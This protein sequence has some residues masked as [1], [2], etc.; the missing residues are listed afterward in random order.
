MED[1]PTGFWDQRAVGLSDAVMRE[2]YR[3]TR[4]ELAASN[5]DDN[6]H[7]PNATEHAW[8]GKPFFTELDATEKPPN[9]FS[10]SG[11]QR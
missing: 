5:P 10:L 1:S 11:C 8:Q 6:A 2:H 9:G 7:V 3:L 4:Q